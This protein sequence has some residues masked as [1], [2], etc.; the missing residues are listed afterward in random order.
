MWANL[1]RFVW[2]WRAVLITTPSMAGLVLLMRSLCLLQPSE[3]SAFDQYMRLR[4]QESADDRIAI[5]TIDE[6]DVKKCCYVESRDLLQLIEKLKEHQPRAIGLDIYSHLIA[7]ENKEELQ[8]AIAST[9]NMV[10][11]KKMSVL[12]MEPTVTPPDKLRAKAQMSAS[13]HIF[14][15]DM[16]VRRGFLSITMK[17][18]EIIPSLSLDLAVRYLETEGI[19]LQKVDEMKFRLGKAVF[20]PFGKNDGGYED[21]DDMGYQIILNY[22]N[23]SKNFNMV[24]MTDVLQNRVPPEWGRD[25]IVLI[26]PVSEAFEDLVLTPYSGGLHYRP[27]PIPGVEVHAHSIGQILSAA[28]E[29]RPLFK[30]WSQ[31]VEWLWILFWAGVGATLNWS[32][33]YAGESKSAS[34]FLRGFAAYIVAVIALLASTYAAFLGAWWLPVVPP[35]LSLTGASIVI[36]AYIARTA[37]E[38]RE[39]FGRYLTDAI[40]ANLLE[41]PEGMKLGG[42][43]RKITILTSDLRGFTALSERLSPEEVVKILNIYLES[44]ADVITK[45]KGT[46]DEFM[47]DGILVLFGAPITREDDPKRAVA[48]AVDMQ[49]AMGAVNKK[50]NELD[51][52]PLQMGIG[53]NTGE[54]VVGNI[55]SYKRTKYGVVGS[56]VN[57]T[58]RIESYTTVGQILISEST[59]K[60]VENIVKIDGEKQVTPKGVKQPITIYEVGGIAG[61]YNLFLPKEEEVFV[62]LTEEISMQYAVLDGKNIGD[63]AFKGS[64][65]KLS[66]KGAEVRSEEE[67]GFVPPALTNIKMNLLTPDSEEVSEDIYAKVL[68]KSAGDG[69]FHIYFTAIPPAVKER[70]DAI[71]KAGSKGDT[72][73]SKP[74]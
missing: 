62:R 48:C 55:G 32:L 22:R 74:N 3:L 42:E 52:P 72:D 44:M 11:V 40:V 28:L 58:Y 17:N 64:F 12:E 67:S 47:G 25:R 70:L 5:V 38:I 53:I 57:L 37:G 1:K 4:P 14:D 27:D 66:A 8:Q 30:S 6:K 73:I 46:I 34:S 26:G 39:T 60:D 45:Y 29:G 21:A 9:P 43:R 13:K 63:T 56:Q 65:V 36:T 2:E 16:R 51:L 19:Y 15:A 24:S 7:A 59:F 69:S 61:E 50:M 20:A 68:D 54:V 10:A 71:Y 49:L 18:G 35:F 41:N 31:P 23:T 33:R